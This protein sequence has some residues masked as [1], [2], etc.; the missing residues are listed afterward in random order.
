[1][2]EAWPGPGQGEKGVKNK[3]KG[4][5]GVAVGLGAERHLSVQPSPLQ[6]KR[7]AGGM[8]ESRVSHRGPAPAH[9]VTGGDQYPFAWDGR[10]R[11]VLGRG[12]CLGPEAQDGPGERDL[13]GMGGAGRSWG[14]GFVWDRRRRTVLGRGICLG[15][16]AQDGPGER[17]LP[18]TGGAGRSWG[19]GFA[20]DGRRGTVLGRGMVGSLVAGG[21]G[22]AEWQF[23][24]GI[25]LPCGPWPI[26]GTQTGTLPA[27][28]A[29]H[30]RW[31]PR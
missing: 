23:P 16:E 7:L 21:R 27:Y 9:W 12:I 10:C 31:P 11:T 1:M 13:S 4:W 3:R 5:G 24:A 14:E 29:R 6:I 2:G 18:G 19:E 25:S 8:R 15:R 20:W 26:K 28:P 22:G 30:H 17:D